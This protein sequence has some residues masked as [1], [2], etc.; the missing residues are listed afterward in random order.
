M[1]ARRE[2][3]LIVAH[4]ETLRASIRD[5]FAHG[6][7]YTLA[8]ATSFEEALSEVLLTEFDLIITQAH[9][10]DLSGLDLLAAVS[11]LRPQT[12]VIIIDEMLSAKGA[13]AVFRLG[14]ADYLYQP[15]QMSFL[16]MQAE[17]QLEIKRNLQKK[18]APY[19]NGKP[20]GT[21]LTRRQ[22]NKISLELSQLQQ[23]TRATFTCLLD[24]VGNMLGFVGTLDEE[25]LH[26]L[27]QALESDY[28]TLPTLA[29][30]SDKFHSVHYVGETLHVYMVRVGNPYKVLLAV[31]TQP[32]AQP[33]FVW[34]H[35]KRATDSI[36]N[37]LEGIPQAR[38]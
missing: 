23:Q 33:E 6:G 4:D 9:L 17:R 27:T 2:R 34:L 28:A 12:R 38:S 5:I 1:K 22:L 3:I 20:V 19:S 32:K 18:P 37:L 7:E 29:H 30:P 8:Q 31:V 16:L 14:G 35:S 13:L 11:G 15:L 21:T 36:Y 24:N 26:A 25:A 10:P